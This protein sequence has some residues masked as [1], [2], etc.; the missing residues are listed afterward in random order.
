M[1]IFQKIRE[2]KRLGVT[3]AVCFFVLA[4]VITFWQ[5]VPEKKADLTQLY[6]TVDDGKTWFA[7][8]AY[9]IAPFDKDGKTAVIAEVFSYDNGSKKF[10]AYLAKYTPEAKKKLEAAIANAQAKGQD[11]A[12]I[13]H[14]RNI[15]QNGMLVKAIGED[16][17]W[18]PFNDPRAREIFSFQSPDGSA[19]DQVLVY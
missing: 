7:D 5:Y 16:K 18:V 9:K 6:Y 8:S 12:A 17:P 14:D 1:A 13:L 4:F 3:V 15:S 2:N 10:C 11:P 19:Y